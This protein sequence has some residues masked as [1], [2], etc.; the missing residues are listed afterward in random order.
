MSIYLEPIGIEVEILELEFSAFVP[1]FREGRMHGILSNLPRTITP[2]IDA[3]RTF[4]LSL[5]D[6]SVAYSETEFIEENYWKYRSSTDVEE[7]E[8]LLLAMGQHKYDEYVEVPMFWLLGE[9][10]ADPDI[11][12]DHHFSGG[13]AGTYTHWEFTEAVAR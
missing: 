9:V 3:I 10:V 1:L 5:P 11:I 12:K 13:I 2:P 7:R 6:G 4:N 8:Q